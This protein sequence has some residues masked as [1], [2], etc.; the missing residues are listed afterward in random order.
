[1]VVAEFALPPSTVDVTFRTANAASSLPNEVTAPSESVRVKDPVTLPL[2]VSFGEPGSGIQP[3]LAAFAVKLI[4][5]V[6]EA[7]TSTDVSEIFRIWV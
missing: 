1:M 5:S 4:E 3:V 2:R 7:T 6:L